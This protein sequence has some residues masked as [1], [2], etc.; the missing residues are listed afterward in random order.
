MVYNVSKLFLVS[1]FFLQNLKY[2]YIYLCITARVLSV[3]IKYQASTM[4]YFPV[5]VAKVFSNALYKTRRIMFV[6]EELNVRFP[7]QP[8]KSARPADLTNASRQA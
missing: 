2:L 1:G 3:A 4:E 7:S 5:K 8:E 6:F